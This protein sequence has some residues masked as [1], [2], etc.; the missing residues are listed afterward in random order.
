MSLLRP[1]VRLRLT[2]LYGVL[3]LVAGLVLITV[4][5]GLVRRELRPNATHPIVRVEQ[6]AVPDEPDGDDR[7]ARTRREERRFALSQLWRQSLL[8]LAIATVGALAFGW[9]LAGEVL[10]PL[11]RITAHAQASSATTLDERIELD[12]PDDELKELADTFDAMLDRLQAAFRAQ[13]AFA[14]QASHELRTPLAIIRAEAEVCAAAPDATAMQKVSSAAILSAVLRS[15]RLVDGLLALTRSESTMLEGAPIDL[16]DLAG[17]VLGEYVQEA[18]QAKVRLDLA[19]ESAP[20]RGD[21][22]LL[23]RMIGNLV[24]NA[25]RYNR[26]NGSVAVSVFPVG[27]AARITVEN[28]GQSLS[29]EEIDALFQPFMRG[30][31]ARR[32]RTGFGLGL[33]IVRSI[34]TA[35]RGTVHAEPAP[36]GGLR[37]TVEIPRLA[38]AGA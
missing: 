18:D 25:I 24:Q 1:T 38:S 9:I 16:A 35:H 32:N 2:L 36:D 10:H 19:L 21:S 7:V 15:E 37:V 33:A 28:S 6:Q 17:D 12:G 31:W 29:Q 26:P 27:P 14:A 34:A 22:A 3:F 4:T 13:Q 30:A 23:H 5:Y 20:V 11:Q 8:A